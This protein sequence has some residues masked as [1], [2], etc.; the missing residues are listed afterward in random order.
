M[1]TYNFVVKK[2]QADDAGRGRVRIHYKRR[3]GAPRYSVM[4]LTSANR[5]QTLVSALGHDEGEEEIWM[6][7][8]LR[9][10]FGVKADDKIEITVSSAGPLDKL[11]WYLSAA[12]P[13]VRIP[14]WLALWSVFLGAAGVVLGVIS[15]CK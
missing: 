11:W 5:V 9:N 8:D 3:G 13:A 2:A 1:S 7:F 12:D 6:D 10:R 4:R 15:L 14:A